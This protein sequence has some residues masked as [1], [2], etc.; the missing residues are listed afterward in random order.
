MENIMNKCV[1]DTILKFVSAFDTLMEDKVLS[2]DVD[3][4]DD[5]MIESIKVESTS[6]VAAIMC[7]KVFD[8][9]IFPICDIENV[10]HHKVIGFNLIRNEYDGQVDEIVVIPMGMN[11]F[12]IIPYTIADIMWSPLYKEVLYA[13]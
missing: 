12:S 13:E 8:Q 1:F 4:D 7:G 6:S 3:R 10:I 5:G 11:N 2:L 9:I